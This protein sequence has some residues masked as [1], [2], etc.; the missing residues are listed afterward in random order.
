MSTLRQCGKA[1]P[2]YSCSCTPS[3]QRSLPVDLLHPHPVPVPQVLVEE[4]GSRVVGLA[5]SLTG[6]A[7]DHLFKVGHEALIHSLWHRWQVISQV[8]AWTNVWVGTSNTFDS[9]MTHAFEGQRGP[10][11]GGV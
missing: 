1:V 5:H 2:P 4:R 8:A 3:S 6:F 10:C 7:K 9:T 11:Q